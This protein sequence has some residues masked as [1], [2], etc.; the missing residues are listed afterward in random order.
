MSA[1]L[2]IWNHGKLIKK[3]NLS[4]GKLSIGRGA[5]CGLK[6]D[7]KTIS[8]EHAIIS[9]GL[10]GFKIKD[11]GGRNGTRVNGHLVKTQRLHAG[12]RIVIGP[13]K[14]HFNPGNIR[15]S[16]SKA[17]RGQIEVVLEGISGPEKGFRFSDNALLLKVGRERGNDIIFQKDKDVAKYH[18]KIFFEGDHYVIQDLHTS[19]GTFLNKIKIQK[20]TLA[21]NDIVRIGQSVF[22]YTQETVS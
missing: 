16:E 20:H 7:C 4:H 11:H 21:S 17:K 18:A 12:D 3:L 9:G 8:K 10:F 22:K 19:S 2:L 15:E 6:L 13:Y 14:M 1:T 5:A